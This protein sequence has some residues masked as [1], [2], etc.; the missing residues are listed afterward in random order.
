M[1]AQIGQRA[2]QQVV[3]VKKAELEAL[4]QAYLRLAEEAERPDPIEAL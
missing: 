2:R 1:A 4:A 3:P